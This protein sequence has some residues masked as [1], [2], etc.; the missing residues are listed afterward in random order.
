[1]IKSYKYRLHPNKTQ[2]EFFEKSFGCV[3]F[4]YNWALNQRIEAYQ[5][6]GI[7]RIDNDECSEEHAR[8]MVRGFAAESMGYYSKDSLVNYDKAQ[9][10]LG[11]RTRNKFKDICDKYHIE[12]KTINNQP[13]GFLRTEIE[14]LKVQLELEKEKADV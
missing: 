14:D 13:V 8:C 1:M 9:K 10:I 12:Q 2:A 3:R 7:R 5:K 4:V 11:I 6:D